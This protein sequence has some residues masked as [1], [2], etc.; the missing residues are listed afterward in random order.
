MNA[1]YVLQEEIIE[2]YK[3][4]ALQIKTNNSNI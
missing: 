4:P 2:T 1:E 3:N